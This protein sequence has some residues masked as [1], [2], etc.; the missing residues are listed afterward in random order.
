MKNQIQFKKIIRDG[1]EVWVMEGR[2]PANVSGIPTVLRPAAIIDIN[3]FRLTKQEVIVRSMFVEDCLPVKTIAKK[4]GIH[5]NT[6]TNHKRRI[7]AKMNVHCDSEMF[8][9]YYE[10]NFELIRK[11]PKVKPLYP[12]FNPYEKVA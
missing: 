4:L 6:V 1:Q 11:D 8:K 7:Y 9:A 5:E 3:K 10:E 12:Y 2:E